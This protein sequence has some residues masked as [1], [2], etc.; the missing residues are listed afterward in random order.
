MM[1]VTETIEVKDWLIEKL[2]SMLTELQAENIKLREEITR[3][4]EIAYQGYEQAYQMLLE[5]RGIREVALENA[6][7]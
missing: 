5:V 1:Q 6:N 3:Q 2:Q 7:A 4:E